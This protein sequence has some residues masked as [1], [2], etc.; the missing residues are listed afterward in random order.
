MKP[1]NYQNAWA[2][3]MAIV[4][5]FAQSH[6]EYNFTPFDFDENVNESEYPAG[7]LIGIYQLDYGEDSS[8]MTTRLMFVIS[9]SDTFQLNKAV[10][11]FVNYVAEQTRHPLYNYGNQA[12]IGHLVALNEL[13][14]SPATKSTNRQ[15]KFILQG[16]VFDRSTTLPMP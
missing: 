5:T 16:F 12:V 13:A 14:V 7:N 15:F 9:I 10:G 1:N 4:K 11:E 6:S 2:S 8:M 3:M